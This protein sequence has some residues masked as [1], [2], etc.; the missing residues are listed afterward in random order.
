MK[1]MCVEFF[2]FNFWNVISVCTCL[3]SLNGVMWFVYVIQCFLH[4][5][6]FYIHNIYLH[7]FFIKIV[8]SNFTWLC[9]D[10]LELVFNLNLQ[11]YVITN[12]LVQSTA[13]IVALTVLQLTFVCQYLFNYG[14]ETISRV[15]FSS[16]VRQLAF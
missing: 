3:V 6:I 10:D 5:T 1:L 14:R 7:R 4:N 12:K 16:S 13:W 2:L 15:T 9:V 11:L 8:F